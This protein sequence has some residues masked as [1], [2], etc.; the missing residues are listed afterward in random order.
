MKIFVFC[1]S[2]SH[3]KGGAE[4]IAT[5]L[6]YEMVGRGHQLFVGYDGAKAQKPAYSQHD[7]AILVPFLENEAFR[8]EI[9][10]INPDIFFVFYFNADLMTYRKLCPKNIPFGMQEC[11]NPKRLCCDNWKSQTGKDVNATWEREIIASSATRIRMVMP[12]Y[13]NSFPP[14]IRRNVRAFP[15]SAPEI[16]IGK[17]ADNSGVK[18]KRI[19]IVG[20]LKAN[21]NLVL[22]IKAFS[23]LPSELSNWEVHD[24]GTKLD[25]Q[26][27]YHQ[28]IKEL[29]FTY[30]LTDRIIFNGPTD[31]IFKEY[32][33]ADIHVIPS[34]SEGCPTCVL[35]AM[36]HGIPSVGVASCPG[37]NELIKHN[38]NG[39]LVNNDE[40]GANLAEALR[41]LMTSSDIR[42]KMG[43][44]AYIDAKQFQPQE[45]YD[46]WE[47]LFKEMANYKGNPNMLFQEQTTI[48]KERAMH[49]ARCRRKLFKQE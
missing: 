24:Y 23:R 47:K 10:K 28:I 17:V 36:A 33:K 46:S 31:D 44:Q 32:S 19:I 20:G 2:L 30:K 27:E 29:V 15:N 34:L 21:K 41:I 18:R 25:D 49:M 39:I 42:K 3:G 14:Y 38:S 13:E 6:I 8:D 4:R 48:D 1:A 40:N 26:N 12:G 22:L 7:K 35:E 11:T 45:T 5:N 16:G 9:I 37:T 43:G